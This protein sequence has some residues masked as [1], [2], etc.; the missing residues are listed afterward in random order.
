VTSVSAVAGEL[1]SHVSQEAASSTAGSLPE[2]LRSLS[3]FISARAFSF[4]DAMSWND[5]G[6]CQPGRDGVSLSFTAAPG[7][8]DGRLTVARLG[9]E[10]FQVML[11][12]PICHGVVRWELLLHR[13][14]D[15]VI[16]CTAWPVIGAGR[17]YDIP[18]ALRNSWIWIP[19]Q[20]AVLFRGTYGPGGPAWPTVLADGASE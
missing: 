18:M 2:W 6:L 7:A 12:V 8:T 4:A 20:S 9:L 16:G 1:G 15:L 14:N 3:A 10:P 13:G 17:D 5:D 19:Y 11:G